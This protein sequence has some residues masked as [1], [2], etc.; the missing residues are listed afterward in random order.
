MVPSS[1]A[2]N[3][4]DITATVVSTMRL[5][6]SRAEYSVRWGGGAAAIAPQLIDATA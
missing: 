4:P 3:I 1:E 6:D 5:R 2:R